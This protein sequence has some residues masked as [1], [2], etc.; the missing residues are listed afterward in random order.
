MKRSATFMTTALAIVGLSSTA[1]AASAQAIYGSP[2]PLAAPGGYVVRETVVTPPPLVRER[3][4]V[5]SRPAYVPVA[6]VPPLAPPYGYT[7]RSYVV[8][9]W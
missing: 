8:S 2:Y 3:T 1:T 9:D 6:P 5:V 7:E 4:V